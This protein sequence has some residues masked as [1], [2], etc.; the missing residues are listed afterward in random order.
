MLSFLHRFRLMQYA[1]FPVLCLPFCS[2]RSVSR[3]AIGQLVTSPL[4]LQPQGAHLPEP[5]C[6]AP[7]L[8]LNPCQGIRSLKSS[9]GAGN[10]LAIEYRP[11]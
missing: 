2:P 3:A 9:S 10:M 8:N 6:E 4:P 5:R 1:C 11:L 7:G